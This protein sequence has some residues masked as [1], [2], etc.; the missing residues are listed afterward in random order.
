MRTQHPNPPQQPSSNEPSPRWHGHALP[1]P[2][3]VRLCQLGIQANNSTHHQHM[4]KGSPCT[5]HHPPL[6]AAWQLCSQISPHLGRPTIHL[7]QW[8][9]LNTGWARPE[10]THS[11][12]VTAVDDSADRQP[13]TLHL[14]D[15]TALPGKT[16]AP[17]HKPNCRLGLAHICWLQGRCPGRHH[18]LRRLPRRPA[19]RHGQQLHGST[20]LQSMAIA[21]GAPPIG[22]SAGP[23]GRGAGPHW[24]QGYVQFLC[25][26]ERP[27]GHTAR[28]VTQQQGT[29]GHTS[30]AVPSDFPGPVS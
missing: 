13:H 26:G 28:P 17:P 14:G 11:A 27:S 6:A 19:A 23:T 30:T 15:S 16:R 29:T 9:K 10:M 2:G 18:P 24:P 25:A 8:R 7:R 22:S 20:P 5:H 1:E 4:T 21:A 3:L 12:A